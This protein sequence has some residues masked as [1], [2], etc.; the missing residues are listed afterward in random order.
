M[1]R[2][3]YSQV[4]YQQPFVFTEILLKLKAWNIYNHH[5][6]QKRHSAELVYQLLSMD[7]WAAA[8]K[9]FKL[10]WRCLEFLP[11]FLAKGNL[12]WVWR[13]SAN[14]KDDDAQISWHLHYSWGK[15]RKNSAWRYSVKAV[16]PAITS[17]GVHYLQSTSVREKERKKEKSYIYIYEDWST[18][19]V[20]RLWTLRFNVF[21]SYIHIKH[22]SSLRIFEML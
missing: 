13:Q 20:T 16:W 8:K 9:S 12:P 15:Y 14:Y 5:H 2:F 17:N 22:P 19:N 1:S 18:R 11:G 21:Y 7:P 6:T 3:I 4:L 10:V